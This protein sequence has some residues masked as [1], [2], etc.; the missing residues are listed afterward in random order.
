MKDELLCVSQ[1]VLCRCEVCLDVQGHHFHLLL[2][3]QV[4]KMV[5]LEMII[6]CGQNIQLDLD[7]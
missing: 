3:Y 2:S 4:S 7:K 6:E 5:L 1:Y